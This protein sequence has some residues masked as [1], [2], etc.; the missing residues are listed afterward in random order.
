M[1]AGC[2][3]PAWKIPQQHCLEQ[4]K[5]TPLS[6]SAESLSHFASAENAHR[7]ALTLGLAPCIIAGQEMGYF[8]CPYVSEMSERLLCFLKRKDPQRDDLGLLST[9]S[10]E[11]WPWEVLDKLFQDGFGPHLYIHWISELWSLWWTV[12]WNGTLIWPAA[13]I[14]TPVLLI[15]FFLCSHLREAHL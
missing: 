2:R 5:H 7:H 11:G 3:I 10:L 13:A 14:N 6:E 12:L 9:S 15:W 8:H 1:Q 4:M